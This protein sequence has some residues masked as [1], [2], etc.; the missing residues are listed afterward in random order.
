MTVRLISIP[1]NHKYLIPTL[2]LTLSL[3]LSACT[4]VPPTPTASPIPATATSAAASATPAAAT[5]TPLPVVSTNTAAPITPTAAP[6]A[7]AVAA[8][9]TSS[10]PAL[11]TDSLVQLVQSQLPQGAFEGVTALPLTVAAGQPPLWA[12]YSRGLRN[13]DQQPLPEHFVAIYTQ[14]D[15]KWKELARQEFSS[16]DQTVSAP[17]YMEDGGLVQT[18]IEPT[19]VWLA[20]EGGAGAHSGVFDLLDFDGQALH[21]QL[22]GFSSS[23][24]VGSIEDV[25]GDGV[26]DV[27]LDATDYYVFCYACG[28]RDIGFQVFAWDQANGRMLERPIEPMLM[29]QSGHPARDLTNEAVELAQ[30]GLWKDAA[31][32]IEQAK[33]AAA[34]VQPPFTNDT[35]DWDHGLI[36]LQAGALADAAANSGYPLLSQVFNGDYAAAVDLMRPYTA[37]QIFNAQSPL[38]VGTVAEMCV[39]ELSS[40]IT[41]KADAALALKPDLAPAYFL[42]GWASYLADPAANRAQAKADVAKAAALAPGDAFY[43]EAAAFLAGGSN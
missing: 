29:G 36:K 18:Q 41:K 8:T 11:S 31:V 21:V 3:A 32:V 40:S 25:N 4:V 10:A 9:P 43:R 1:P 27:V 33:Q 14:A 16:D 35:V 39:P 5:A 30:A 28:V 42:R 6:T 23:P 2:L 24:G 22:N 34:N 12:V 19:H 13:F 15:G 17:D 38:I 37:A 26:P 20:L 7:T